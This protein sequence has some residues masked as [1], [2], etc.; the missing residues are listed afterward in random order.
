MDKRKDN[1]LA[2]IVE[3]YAKT[4]EP[5]ASKFIA[6]RAGFK[7]SPATIRNDMM[8]LEK[9]GLVFQPYTSA[10]RVPT[11]KGY[12]YYVDNFL[13]KRELTNK[14]KQRLKKSLKGEPRIA[15]KNLAKTLAEISGLG[16]LVAFSRN[17]VYYTGISNLFSQPEF[18][19]H[20]LV[21]NMSAVI[22]HLDEAVGKIFSEINSDVKILIGKDNPFGRDCSVL[23]T[24]FR[25]AG[26]ETSREQGCLIGI[27]GPMRMDY[28]R[29]LTLLSAIK[30]LL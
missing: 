26:Q 12:Q 14:E 17:D 2:A 5:V 22:D 24:R 15:A 6:Q 16:I 20:D 23:L 18:Y 21:F 8:E 9:L 28:Q 10:G 30:D 7:V 27:L 11:E 1:L 4:A 19:N 13:V 25:S 3:Q 29:N